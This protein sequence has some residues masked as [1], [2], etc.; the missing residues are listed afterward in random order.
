MLF[1][2]FGPGVR[3]G[4][5]VRE[6]CHGRRQ[7]HL[8]PG[9]QTQRLVLSEASG[10]GQLE[11]IVNWTDTEVRR[12]QERSGGT[13][14]YSQRDVQSTTNTE[15]PSPLCPR[16]FSFPETFPLIGIIISEL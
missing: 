6:V 4:G 8:V 15:R 5:D 12:D 16:M 13:Y 2:L 9:Q 10:A 11:V 14:H 7:V 1:L 3:Q